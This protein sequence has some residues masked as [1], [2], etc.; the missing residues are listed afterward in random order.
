MDEDNA[1]LLSMAVNTVARC[2]T[3]EERRQVLQVLACAVWEQ[4]YEAALNEAATTK[5]TP[6]PFEG[7]KGGE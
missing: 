3:H 6:N 4:A 5:H 1:V 2:G 7:R